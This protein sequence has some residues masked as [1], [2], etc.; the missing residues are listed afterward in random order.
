MRASAVPGSWR[1]ARGM[2][3]ATR[4]SRDVR[5]GSSVTAF[6]TRGKGCHGRRSHGEADRQVRHPARCPFTETWRPETWPRRVEMAGD[7]PFAGTYRGMDEVLA[8]YRRASEGAIDGIAVG[9]GV[10]GS[11]TRRGGPS[12]GSTRRRSRSARRSAWRAAGGRCRRTED[13]WVASYEDGTVWRIDQTTLRATSFD[14]GMPVV[15][16][17]IDDEGGGLVEPA[18]VPPEPR[19]LRL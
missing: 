14:I 18:L 1:F 7:D 2:F 10:C 11:S 17:A 16:V 12:C 9:A 8:F 6:C 3:V 4:G 15:A 19:S 13:V 5:R